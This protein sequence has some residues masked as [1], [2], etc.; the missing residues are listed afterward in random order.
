MSKLVY[1]K[2]V[3][4]L[5]LEPENCSGCG[6]CQVVCPRGV[7]SGTHKK[8]EILDRDACI[9]CGA[10]AR[11]CP[12]GALSVRVGVGCATALIKI[13]LGIKVSGCDCSIDQYG[14]NE[15]DRSG[16]NGRCC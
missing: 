6:M 9:E 14:M 5:R 1:L 13:P 2:D 10:C 12:E 16:V 3:V 15:K 8:A 4:S 11:N 7:F